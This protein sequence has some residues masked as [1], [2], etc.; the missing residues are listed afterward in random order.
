[1][2]KLL[3]LLFVLVLAAGCNTNPLQAVNGEFG[4][5]HFKTAVSLIEL[6]RVRHGVYPDSLGALEFTGDWDQIALASVDYERVGEGYSLRIVQG[7]AQETP[8]LSYPAAFFKGLGLVATNVQGLPDPTGG[9]PD[10]TS[11]VRP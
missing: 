9:P 5:Q 8:R 1:M 11:G 3:T 6:H 10:S 2:P 7:F 4:D